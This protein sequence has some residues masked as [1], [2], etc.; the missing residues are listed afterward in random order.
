MYS[1]EE[2]IVAASAPYPPHPLPGTHPFSPEELAA[3]RALAHHVP[4]VDAAVAE[5][6]RLKA[7]L[8]L[9]SG[10][11]HIL[12]DI[13][14]DHMK[15]QHVINN[16]S[17]SLRPLVERLYRSHLSPEEITTLL[18]TIYYPA[19]LFQYLGLETADP[20]TRTA[21][22]RRT[23]KWQFE[24]LAALT[25]S[26]SLQDIAH[27]F[28]ADYRTVFWE[29][30]WE[31]I[32]KRPQTYMETMIQTL[33][34]Q[35]KGLQAVRWASR[36]I[37]QASVSEVIVA[38]DLG[39]RG[40]RL[41]KV[42]DLLMHQKRL[43]ITWG[44]HDVS[45]MGACLGHEA[46]IAT[47]LRLSLRYRRLSQLEEGFG[48]TM[49]P[50]EKLAREVY[51][52]DPAS[53]FQPR[54]EGLRDTIQMARMQKAIAVI[55]FKLEAQV[56]NRHPEYQM[57]HRALI[58]QI[59][60]HRGTV[61]LDGQ[62]YPLLDTSFPT[63]DPRKP[64]MLSPEEASCMDRLKRSFLE[65]GP[66]WEQMRF[67]ERR[68]T[69]Y[70]I[71]DGHVIFH[72]CLPVDDTGDFLSM[73]IDGS[74]RRGRELFDAIGGVVHRA[75]REQRLEDLDMLW[76]LWTGPGSPMFGKDKMATFENYFIGDGET[77]HETKNPYFQLIHTPSFCR[78][79]L[80]EFGVD[81][82]MGMIVNGHVPVRVERGELPL[83]KSGQAITIDG[84]FS[85]AYGDRGYTLI[86]DYAGIQ[87]AEHHHFESVSDAL[88][89]GTD[90]IPRVDGIRQ[91]KTP[92]RVAD[93][94]YGAPIGADIKMLERLIEAYQ[95]SLLDE[96]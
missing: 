15:L 70:V 85:E 71:R 80:A 55:Q 83:K 39:D 92:R 20:G 19:Q 21:F 23:L 60:P 72:G 26:C 18:N 34:E 67:V 81:P 8:E 82:E 56:I 75:C 9:P 32:A 12:S 2:I 27:T 58:T 11:I 22:V 94:E 29:L 45:W 28:P 66:L 40:P 6:A 4:T 53:R 90:I 77:H 42:I 86:L 41:D 50:L 73:P 78:Q 16:A 96:L 59:D 54:G 57:D 36:V 64:S 31:A 43:S 48:I 5:I 44:N 10:T 17:G 51:G 84:A 95:A 24:I 62:D 49:Q 3:L 30:L 63:L 65:S 91:Y 46:L 79:V 37:R 1:T 52:A 38:G 33:T 35:G 74:S 25:Q 68:G 76:Y 69:V 7:R 88:A 61:K 89:N 93:T 14:G 87:L 13:H 47:V